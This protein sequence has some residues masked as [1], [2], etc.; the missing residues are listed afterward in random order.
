MLFSSYQQEPAAM[1]G[2]PQQQATAAPPRPDD[3][4]LPPGPD[5]AGSTNARAYQKL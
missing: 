5:W 1:P 2:P 3:H 4:L